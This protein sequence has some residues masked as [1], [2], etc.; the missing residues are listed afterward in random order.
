MR[1]ARNPVASEEAQQHLPSMHL[2][3]CGG[4]VGDIDEPKMCYVRFLGTFARWLLGLTC[5]WNS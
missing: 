3:A 5:V 4:A 1:W 2:Y